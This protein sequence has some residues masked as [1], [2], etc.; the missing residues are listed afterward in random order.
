MRFPGAQHR[1]FRN[2]DGSSSAMEADI[3]VEGFNN[4]LS[5]YG[6]KYTKFIADGDSSV[7]SK[8]LKDVSYGHEVRYMR[9]FMYISSILFIF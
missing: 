1:C 9:C 3:I 5:L 8:I 2:W 7:H 6:L 4:S